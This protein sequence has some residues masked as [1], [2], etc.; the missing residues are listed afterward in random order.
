MVI[1]VW[2]PK[3]GKLDN[4]KCVIGYELA[5]TNQFLKEKKTGWKVRYSCDV[6]KSNI[7]HTTRGGVLFNVKTKLNTI[8]HQTCKNCRSRISEYEIKK[9]YISFSRIEESIKMSNYR[10]ITT[11]NEY[12]GVNNRSQYKHK[13]IC[14]NGHKLT[15]T[16]NNWNKGKRC[17]QCYEKNKFKNA[18]KYKNGWERYKFLI[19]YYTE[20]SYKKHTEMINPNKHLR[21][22]NYHLDHK[23]SIYEGFINGVSP[24]I[25][26]NFHNLI[27][28]TSLENLKK[29][30]KSSITL[31]KLLRY[32]EFN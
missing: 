20:K 23:Y 11:E 1:D 22:K 24:K 4:T 8:N 29:H 12:M 7:I 9:N 32:E 18:V 27:V 5:D 3:I 28:I 2:K 30:K 17:R 19:W 26:G 10:L 21:G 14:N 16:W 25:I 15:T 31:G 13:I 6:C